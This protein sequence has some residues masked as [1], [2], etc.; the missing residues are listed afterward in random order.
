MTDAQGRPK[1]GHRMFVYG[2][3]LSGESNHRLLVGARLIG[4]SRTE[5]SF[6]LRSLGAFP[7]LVPNGT[8]SVLGESYEVDDGTLA[9]L[10]RLE[11]HPSFYT[12]TPV[13]LADGCVAETYLL[14]PDQVRGRP[15]IMSGNWRMHRR[16]HQR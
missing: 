10:D 6:E 11:G 3:L 1:S 4:E 15:A 9:A 16:E 14:R 7:G 5:P 8:C 13:K 2:T 12:R